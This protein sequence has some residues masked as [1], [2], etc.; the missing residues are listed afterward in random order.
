MADPGGIIGAISL[1]L[2][3]TQGL[4]IYYTQFTSYHEDIAAVIARTKRLES[5]LRALEPSVL[6]LGLDDDP[7]SDEIR[8]CIMECIDAVKKLK[9]HQEKCGEV[10]TIPDTLRTRI[11]IAK[12]RLAY[13]FRKDTLEDLNKSLDRFLGTLQVIIQALDMSDPQL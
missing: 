6:R 2:Q 8:S 9:A 7:I 10:D 11:Y 3:V 4:K 13:P 1:A 5:V 12:K